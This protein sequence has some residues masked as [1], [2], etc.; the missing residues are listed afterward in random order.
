M[1]TDLRRHL[2]LLAELD[3]L[4]P[5]RNPQPSTPMADIMFA[6]GGREVVE[7]LQRELK[8]QEERRREEGME[9]LG[10]LTDV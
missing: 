4:F 6:A 7:M 1:R 3:E 2:D 8:Y 5:A 9:V 10:K